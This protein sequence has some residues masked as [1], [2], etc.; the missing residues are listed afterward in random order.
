MRLGTMLF[1]V[2]FLLGQASGSLAGPLDL[3]GLKQLSN[4]HSTQSAWYLTD[5]FA[6][7]GVVENGDDVL[8]VTDSNF[9]AVSMSEP[10][11]RR[12][13]RNF[14]FSMA[15][16]TLSVA[17]AGSPSRSNENRVK[18]KWT[19]KH[20][21][22]RGPCPTAVPEPATAM[23]LVVGLGLAGVTARLGRMW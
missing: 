20:G 3:P 5:D 4:A 14:Q 22:D 9:D 10:Q 7:V 21:C 23:L 2:T 1:G 11:S 16:L 8:L 13:A 15:S 19:A 6:G 17:G 12:D 18:P